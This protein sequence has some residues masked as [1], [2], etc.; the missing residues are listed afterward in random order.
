MVVGEVRIVHQ[1]IQASDRLSFQCE[2]SVPDSNV[3]ITSFVFH[4]NITDDERG[5]PFPVDATYAVH[6]REAGLFMVVDVNDFGFDES[7]P[8]DDRTNFSALKLTG[9]SGIGGEFELLIPVFCAG[10][11]EAVHLE[12]MAP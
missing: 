8:Y 10:D 4:A 5:Q 6:E 7:V 12:L 1:Q 9:T 11:G 2:F 3:R